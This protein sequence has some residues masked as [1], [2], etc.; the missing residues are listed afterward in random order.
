MSK[1]QSWL[2]VALLPGLAFGC[3]RAERVAPAARPVPP[4]AAVIDATPPAAA[5][6]RT[7]A[8]LYASNLLGKYSPCSCAVEPLG[9]LA[10][11]ATIVGQARAESEATVVVDA[12][13]L[14]RAAG[15]VA[16]TERQARLLAAG[17]T[18][19]GLDAFTPGETDLAIG[20]PLLRKLAAAYRIPIVS[21][22]LYGRDGARLFPADRLIE[23][24]G[25][26]I[27]VFGVTA[28]PSADDAN[29]LRADGV[30][31]RDPAD[32]A[33]EAAASLRAR[34]AQ[35]VV[36]LVHAGLPAQNRSLAARLEGVD[37]AVL[38]HSALNLER[39]EKAGGTLLLEAQSEGKDLGRLDLHVVGGGTGF[40][41]R[42]ERAE[43]AAMLADHQQQ[44]AGYDRSLDG[45]DPAALEDYY[46]QRR[47]QLEAA[48]ARETAALAALP[49]VITGSWFENRIIPL[50]RGV[51]DDPQVAG[52]V[53]EYLARGLADKRRPHL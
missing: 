43:L 29:R 26:R 9:G 2:W 44:L 33:L 27:G 19:A 47:Q 11:R 7:I 36:A 37:W 30:V 10:R 31:V 50:G 6:G 45:L 48:I 14:F 40:A 32:A 34:G 8:L 41:D 5:R 23:A 16:E 20:L 15:T 13:D 22:N 51:P 3:R 24:A 53:R 52:L 17:M 28:A 35:L 1:A 25:T 42:G 12:G 18:H 4:P 46:R 21:A 38:G 39:P 49:R